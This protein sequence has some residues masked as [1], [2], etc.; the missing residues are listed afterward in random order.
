MAA[1]LVLVNKGQGAL[2]FCIQGVAATFFA[3]PAPI[4]GSDRA[5]SAGRNGGKDAWIPAGAGRNEGADA[6]DG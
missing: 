6:N 2:A 5:A 3:I 1:R 4:A